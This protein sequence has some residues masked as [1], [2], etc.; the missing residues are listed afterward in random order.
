M[1]LIPLNLHSA[2]TFWTNPQFKLKLEDA[3]DDDDDVCSVVI[4][5]MQKNR[6]KLR[7]EGLD[8]ETIGFA[9]YEVREEL[10]L[11]GALELVIHT[12]VYQTDVCF[13]VSVGLRVF[14]CCSSSLIFKT[15]TVPVIVLG[16]SGERGTS[17]QGLLPL[18]HV[19]GPQQDV[20]Q[21]TG[22]V[23]AIHAAS[24]RVPAGAHHLPAPSRGRLPGQ[25]VLREEGWSSVSVR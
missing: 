6:R 18:P 23:G 2:D 9:V 11:S 17:I 19:E 15:I 1:P 20:H 24:W 8:M 12:V 14:V 4:A 10:T 22:G 5:L 3:D 7:K 21:H 25:A 16:G 13:R